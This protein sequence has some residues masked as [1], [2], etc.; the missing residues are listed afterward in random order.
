MLEAG[1]KVAGFTTFKVTDGSIDATQADLS[2]ITRIEV[3]SGLKI[4]LA[5]IKEI[6]TIV[7]NAATGVIEVE[8]TTEAE[9]TELV[10]LMTDGTITVYGDA[11][12]IDLVAAPEATITA[13][14][15]AAK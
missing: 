6:P 1:S 2:S 9:A 8:V 7:S 11:N 15:F 12:P 14:V 10:T 4:T 3:A 5:Q 13:V